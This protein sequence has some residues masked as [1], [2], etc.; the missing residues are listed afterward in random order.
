MTRIGLDERGQAYY[1]AITSA[2]ELIGVR[3]RAVER[4]ASRTLD[5]GRSLEAGSAASTT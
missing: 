1:D 4:S 5:T 2:Y 3:A